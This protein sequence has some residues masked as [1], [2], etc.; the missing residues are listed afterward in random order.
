MAERRRAR[1]MKN[2]FNEMDEDG[3][4]KINADQFIAKYNLVN[5]ALSKDQVLK[6]FVEAG[7]FKVFVRL[8]VDV[9]GQ[10]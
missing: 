4:G 8:I 2:V 9:I 10:S 5:S 1:S 3:V 6:I 7:E